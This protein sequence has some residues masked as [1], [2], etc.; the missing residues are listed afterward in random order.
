[1]AFRYVIV[2]DAAFIR[3]LIK[4]VCQSVGGV[5]VGESEGGMGTVDLVRQTLPDLIFIDLVLPER[6]GVELAAEIRKSWPAA[7]LIACTSIDTDSVL[8]KALQSGID[9]IISKPFTREKLIQV[10]E[11]QLSKKR[12][13]AT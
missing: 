7:H 4:G 9:E 11:N 12:E 1:M 8:Q 13:V 3:E 6:N 10:L 5:C 2:E